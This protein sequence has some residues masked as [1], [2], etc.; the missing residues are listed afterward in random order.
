MKARDITDLLLLGALW[1]ASFLFTRIA[2][3]EFGPLALVEVRVAVAGLFLGAILAWRRQGLGL[4]GRW[5]RMVLLSLCN[6]AIPF[7]LF[8]YATLTLTAGFASVVNAT[9]PLWAA[10]IAVVW[11]RQH[12]TAAA[13]LGLAVG[14]LG[15]VVLVSGRLGRAEDVATNGLAIAAGLGATGLYGFAVN[16]A[17]KHVAGLSA[18]GLSFATLL[19]SSIALL[20]GALLTWPATP[21][22]ALAWGS[23]IALAIG[24]TGLAY[25]LYY[26]LIE[27]VGP[28]RAITVTYLIPVFGVTWGAV[29]LK[30][31]VTLTMLGGGAVIL[32][33]VALANGML[34]PFWRRRGAV[35]P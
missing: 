11:L 10:A 18:L 29:F 6:T 30:E 16:Y 1:G 35:A 15:V 14:F 19:I 23:A 32:L 13:W 31:T 34:R 28:A 9:A 22:S 4:S 25:L 8:A 24:C 5:P 33:G 17:K 26:R 21:P 7:A 3:P 12:L 20:P 27:H 2:V